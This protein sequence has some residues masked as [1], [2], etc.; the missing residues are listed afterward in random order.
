VQCIRDRAFQVYLNSPEH[1]EKIA[2]KFG[3]E[4]AQH[5]QEMASLNRRR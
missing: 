4:T 5:I 3:A 2:R 1:L